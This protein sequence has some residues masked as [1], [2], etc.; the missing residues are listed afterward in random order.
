[1]TLLVLLSLVPIVVYVIHN[2]RE[3]RRAAV[4]TAQTEALWLAR[5][6]SAEAQ[7]VI[8]ATTKILQALSQMPVV[9]GRHPAQC[10][11]ALTSLLDAYQSYASFGVAGLDGAVWCSAVPLSDEITVGGRSWFQ[12]AFREG[13]LAIG[14]PESD[15]IT[16]K[17]ALFVG[18]PVIDARG[19]VRDVVYAS[20]GLEKTPSPFFRNV[21]VPPGAVA[22][23]VDASGSIVAHAGEG[24]SRG[25]PAGLDAAI[26]GAARAQQ[27]A[28][29]VVGA[30][31]GPRFLS[32]LARL[33]HESG[34]YAWV[35][36]REDVVFAEITRLT[37]RHLLAVGL[38]AVLSLTAAW[39]G[40]EVFVL[41]GVRALIASSRRLASGDWQPHATGS[42]CG[43]IAEL[44]RSFDDAAVAL[45]RRGAALRL[46]EERYR[47]LFQRSLAGLCRVTRDGRILECNEAFAKIVGC[48]SPDEVQRH[49]MA[50]F[51]RN[52]ADHARLLARIRPDAAVVNAEMP[53]RAEEGP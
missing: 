37:T 50:E 41:R 15:L 3:Q 36:R 9:R 22:V 38:L 30:G 32:A 35:G 28:V 31:D 39:C 8:H 53:V 33:G 14:D 6:V 17:R 40:V 27:E 48:A 18:Y 4:A 23:I 13:G 51:Y 42:A 43:E 10:S 25:G 11:A 5:L 49:D 29:A 44:A 46:S 16:G 2:G 47:G 24:D 52:P 1:V 45:A 20:I 19:R 21:Q 12:R 26:S 34:M 7:D